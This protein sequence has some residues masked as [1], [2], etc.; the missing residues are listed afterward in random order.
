ML[1]FRF[2]FSVDKL[3]LSR[4]DTTYIRIQVEVCMNVS[5]VLEKDILELLI[6][7]CRVR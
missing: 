5:I 3:G 6:L 2:G 4:P 1:V 7:P